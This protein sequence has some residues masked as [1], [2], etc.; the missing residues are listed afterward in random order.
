MAQARSYYYNNFATQTAA[1][2]MLNSYSPNMY[3][4]PARQQQKHQQSYMFQP[5]NY[6]MS[7]TQQQST[8]NNHINYNNTA[9]YGNNFML[10]SS[11]QQQ[12]PSL[13]P[14]SAYQS[15]AQQQQQTP[16]T[17]VAPSQLNTQSTFNP[18]SD[19]S[20]SDLMFLRSLD[21]VSSSQPTMD[22]NNTQKS[23]KYTHTDSLFYFCYLAR[24]CEVHHR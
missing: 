13:T 3:N 19:L 1:A 20:V 18:S 4:Q 17:A 22:D 11:T 24:L 23:R 2:G 5:F 10:S 7:N 6:S 8:P 16:S 12:P 21:S 14:S 9:S 15:F